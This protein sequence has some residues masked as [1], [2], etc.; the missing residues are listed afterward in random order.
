MTTILS[1]RGITAAAA[2]TVMALLL[3]SPVDAQRREPRRPPADRGTA[4]ARPAPPERTPP[5]AR[6]SDRTPPPQQAGRDRSR[7]RGGRNAGTGV[8]RDGRDSRGRRYDTRPYTRL[9]PRWQQPWVLPYAY[10]VP[11]G[12]GSYGAYGPGP[13]GYVGGMGYDYA[14]P[15]P[16]PAVGAVRLDVN[17]PGDAQVLVDGY[18]AGVLDDFDSAFQP[19]ELEPGVYRLEI[20]APGYAPL[21]MDI[22]I[23]AGR[24][25]TYRGSLRRER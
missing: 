16:V 8:R 5:E 23:A 9:E 10:A 11:P 24:T 25:L 22:R 14:A 18:L 19:L 1:S 13:Y 6:P 15:A 7:D 12:P 3:G 17:G 20:T 4:P 21:V 2:A